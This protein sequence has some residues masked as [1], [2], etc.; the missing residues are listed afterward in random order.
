MTAPAE[1]AGGLLVLE[2]DGPVASLRINRPEKLNTL[3]VEMGHAVRDLVAELER[4]DTVAVLTVTGTG[5]RAFCAGT[6]VSGLDEYGTLWQMRNRGGDYA[7]DLL[8]FRKPLIAAIQ[9]HCVGG[10]LE[11]ALA[12]DIRVATA[13]A[14]FA[15]GE[16]KLGWIGGS[17]NSQLLTR[18]VGP[19]NAARLLLTGDP[20]DGREAHRIG[21]VQLLVEPE[22]LLSTALELAHRIARNPP[23]AVQLAKHA[24]RVALSTAL[25]VGLAYENDLFAFCMTTDDSKEGMNAFLE[26]RE[27]RFRGR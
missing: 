6:D 21:L 5:E 8:S 3:T 13:D 25:P 17:G 9:G 24:I 26:K 1:L 11:I 27:P 2:R 4:D 15:A 7:L 18:T 22:A 10:G 12:A 23:I 20:I 14:S 16:V 19:G